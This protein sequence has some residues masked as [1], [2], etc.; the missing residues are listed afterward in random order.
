MKP[1][2]QDLHFLTTQLIHII[3]VHMLWNCKTDWKSES[4]T[5]ETYCVYVAYIYIHIRSM[6]TSQY[7]IGPVK[8]N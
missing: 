1:A 7:N 2:D 6:H 3:I 4:H 8:Q 5:M